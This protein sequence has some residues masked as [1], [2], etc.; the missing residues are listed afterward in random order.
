MMRRT[1]GAAV[2]MVAI[3]TQGCS[4]IQM[5][6]TKSWNYDLRDQNGRLVMKIPEAGLTFH[7]PD[8]SIGGTT[9]G[10]TICVAGNAHQQS[11]GAI[12][13]LRIDVSYSQGV[14]TVSLDRHVITFEQGGSV[15]RCNGNQYDINTLRQ[16]DVLFE[17]DGRVVVTTWNR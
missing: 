7:F 12:G 3:V 8:H 17:R 4:P 14:A 2:C 5:S 13:T 9:S 1:M 10:G 16:A 15:I 6:A 11:S